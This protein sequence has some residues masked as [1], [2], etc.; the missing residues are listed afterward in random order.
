VIII[1]DCR[2]GKRFSEH[3]LLA[4]KSKF[5]IVLQLFY[6]GMGTTN[7]LRGQSALCNVGAFDYTVKNLLTVFNSCFAN[8]NLLTQC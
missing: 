8:V 7:P 6:D 1:T 5:T 3:S 2:D 4:D